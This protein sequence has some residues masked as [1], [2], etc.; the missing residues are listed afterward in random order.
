MT[1]LS[2][3]IN[4]FDLRRLTDDPSV[5]KTI[6]FQQVRTQI[7]SPSTDVDEGIREMG[8]TAPF[9]TY[10][11]KDTRGLCVIWGE[12]FTPVP[13]ENKSV[14]LSDPHRFATEWELPEDAPSRIKP[15]MDDQATSTEMIQK[16]FCYGPFYFEDNM[17]IVPR[18]GYAG[19]YKCYP[20][21]DPDRHLNALADVA[22][23]HIVA[24]LNSCNG[25]LFIGVDSNGI[26]VEFEL[27]SY[28]RDEILLAIDQKITYITPWVRPSL[29]KIYYVPVI[30]D[31]V[32][33]L[34]K[35]V[36]LVIDVKREIIR[37][38]QYQYDDYIHWFKGGRVVQSTCLIPLKMKDDKNDKN[39]KN[40]K[41]AKK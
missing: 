41:N 22:A 30:G 15:K 19:A 23:T 3:I 5:M 28:Q 18:A 1:E 31:E 2:S 26:P 29:Y 34:P 17:R 21:Y 11:P 20:D 9:R 33:I 37:G 12:N 25:T 8:K 35:K 10:E 6:S 14:R 38:K 4:L 32:G 13:P 40:A 7:K 24:F 36:I 39:A 16:S 27:D